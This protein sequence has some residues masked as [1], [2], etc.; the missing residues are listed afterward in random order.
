MG[1]AVAM[2]STPSILRA[3]GRF[4]NR[5][6]VMQVP[7]AAGGPTDVMARVMA[8]KLSAVLGQPV[9]VENYGGAGGIIGSQRTARAAPDGYTIGLGH[10]GTLAANLAFYR[11]LPYQPLESFA[12]IGQYG[13][14]PMV[15]ALRPDLAKDMAGF[16]DWAARNK[17]RMTIATAGTGSVSYLGA[18]LLDRAIGSQ[19]T[20]VP[21][22]GAG[23][24][25]QDTM[26]GVTDAIVDQALTV[27]PQVGNDMLRPLAVTVKGRLPQLPDTPTSAEIGL[28]QFDIAVWNAVVAPHGT[29]GDVTTVLTAAL[30][31]VLDD[32]WVRTR[33]TELAVQIPPPA[34]RGP[35][36]LRSTMRREADR[37]IS[38]TREAGIE[39]Q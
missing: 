23:P 30:D 8:Q 2:L 15:L 13:T 10:T 3:E 33:F 7:F 11:N 19:A 5:P 31:K 18:L 37:W 17:G 12:L 38:L 25:L 32:P 21:Y 4:P 29:P 9:P 34:E 1:T 20:L 36:P 27:I 24:A 16:R 39:P 26:N 28:P 35:E 6:V 22:R 14:N